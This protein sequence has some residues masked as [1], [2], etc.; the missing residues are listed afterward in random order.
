MSGDILS[1]KHAGVA[2]WSPQPPWGVA[3][4]ANWPDVKLPIIF[5]DLNYMYD[6]GTVP[7][8]HV[9][10]KPE[11]SEPYPIIEHIRRGDYDAD[12]DLW[13]RQI[14][15]Y[16]AAG[17]KCVIVPYPEMNGIWVNYGPDKNNFNVQSSVD[18][19]RRFVK[20][21]KELG[22][23]GDKV[24]WC[25]APNDIGWGA[26]KNYWPGD[27]FVDIVGGSAYNWG[28]MTS[29]DDSLWETPKQ[30][31][32]PYIEMVRKVTNKPIIITQTGSASG[33]RR[34]LQWL[35]D[36]VDYAATADIEGFIWFSIDEFDYQPGPA[37][38][39]VRVSSM[40]EARPD[41]W[42]EKADVA[43]PETLPPILPPTPQKWVTPFDYDQ[44]QWNSRTKYPDRTKLPWKVDK[45]VI[46]WGGYT[47]PGDPNNTLEEQIA[48]EMAI[49]RGWQRNHI[50]T[51]GWTDI[52]YSYAVGNSGMRY[53]LRGENRAGATRGD[54]EGDGIPEN[55]EAR[56]LVWI[57]GQGHEPSDAAY[58]S[59]GSMVDPSMPVILHFEVRPTACP[60]QNW[61][62]WRDRK[63]WEEGGTIT[64]PPLGEYQMRT[65]KYGAGSNSAP[66]ASVAAAQRAMS[67]KGYHDMNTVDGECG[68]DG[69]FRSGTELQVKNFQQ[70]TGL[71]IDGVVGDATWAKIDLV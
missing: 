23:T 68:A 9:M 5:E 40:D 4:S 25:W 7:F 19:Y 57:G 35:D 18:I 31:I 37:D 21:G 59:M 33:D 1:R 49:L 32:D 58:R 13:L 50:D 22:L 55:E 62:A 17:R 45:T 15:T 43:P 12:I 6:S 24:L 66:D 69:I 52:A 14:K 34:T 28:G 54:Y 51:R 42:F 38:F 39:N 70:A 64:P 36:L 63:G 30:I 47:N 20:R 46:H 27:D 65:L 56:A 8:L 2:T 71:V 61:A 60:G 67:V 26:T 48:Y 53:R 16:V 44:Y 29:A 11:T 3:L 41:Y 10:F